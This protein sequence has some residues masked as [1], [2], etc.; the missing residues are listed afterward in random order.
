MFL[1]HRGG[2]I[3]DL[4]ATM[5]SRRLNVLVAALAFVFPAGLLAGPGGELPPGTSASPELHARLADAQRKL[6]KAEQT[7]TVKR[8][9]EVSKQYQSV[10]ESLRKQQE[11]LQQ[12]VM[13]LSLKPEVME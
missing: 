5:K 1:P 4:E 9:N 10:G 6:A 8:F 3:E 13:E 11:P 12:E 2:S 7:P